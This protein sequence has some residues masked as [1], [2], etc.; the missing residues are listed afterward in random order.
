[1]KHLQTFEQF[2]NESISS[3]S[4]E[5]L[6]SML[7]MTDSLGL[8]DNEFIKD[9]KKEVQNQLSKNVSKE[10]QKKLNITDKK[11]VND[12][13]NN[14]SASLNKIKDTQSL[15]QFLTDVSNNNSFMNEAFNFDTFFQSV[16]QSLKNAGSKIAEWWDNNKR[17]IMIMIIEFLV[18]IALELIFG[19][20]GAL[21]NAKNLKAPKFKMSGGSFGGGGAGGDF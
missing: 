2:L 15:I 8:V 9:I 21:L 20:I 12:K 7:K 19:L 1:M 17:E 5:S 14:M 6:I 11:I 3:S 18:Q 4:V 10:A 16:K 13:I